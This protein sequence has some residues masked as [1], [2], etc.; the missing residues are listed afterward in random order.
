MSGTGLIALIS[1]VGV[2]GRIPILEEF[3]LLLAIHTAERLKL[4]L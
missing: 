3:P 1:A 2:L 4:S